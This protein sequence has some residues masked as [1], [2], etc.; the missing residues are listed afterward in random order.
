MSLRITF[1]VTDLPNLRLHVQTLSGVP[2]SL[3]DQAG[4]LTT[5]AVTE[6][7]NFRT[8]KLTLYRTVTVINRRNFLPI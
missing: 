5:L 2:T 1:W 8:D 4:T 6:I 7:L 3:D